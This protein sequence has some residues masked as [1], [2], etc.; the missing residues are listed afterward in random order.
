[1]GSGSGLRGLQDRLAAVGG[2]LSV[3]SPPG[4]GT[5]LRATIPASAGEDMPDPAPELVA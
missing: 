5:C 1:V 4:A 3:T 2:T